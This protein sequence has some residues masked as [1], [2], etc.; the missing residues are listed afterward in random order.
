[1]FPVVFLSS[2]LKP[3]FRLRFEMRFAKCVFQLILHTELLRTHTRIDDWSLVYFCR[4]WNKIAIMLLVQK[5][6]RIEY[7]LRKKYTNICILDISYCFEKFYVDE[8]FCF[9]RLTAHRYCKTCVTSHCVSAYS[10]EDLPTNLRK[11]RGRI[12]IIST[13]DPSWSLQ[14]FLRWT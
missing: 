11:T 9:I 12:N 3:S 4:S 10:V 14:L 7:Y 8:S 13:S 6:R 2:N 5:Q 1:M